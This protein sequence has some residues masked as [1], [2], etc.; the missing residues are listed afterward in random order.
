MD[1][2]WKTVGWQS[3]YRI[4]R[5][6]VIVGILKRGSWGTDTYGEYN[7]YLVRFDTKGFGKRS[8]RILDIEGQKVLGSVKF[9]RFPTS[10]TITYE[11]EEYQWNYQQWS[12]YKWSVRHT[13]EEATYVAA[14]PWQGGGGTIQYDYLHPAI[15]LVGLYVHSYFRQ[16]FRLMVLAGVSIPALAR[17]LMHL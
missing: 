17:L 13:D 8:A 5:E 12:R 15:V 14:R 2:Y 1:I 11:G 7:G 9:R 10:A 6:K 4:F 3:E 16:R